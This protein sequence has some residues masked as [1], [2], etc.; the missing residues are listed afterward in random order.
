MRKI[1]VTLNIIALVVFFLLAPKLL[2]EREASAANTQGSGA[3]FNGSATNGCIDHTTTT[4]IVSNDVI[5]A[6]PV[7]GL[8]VYIW[9]T[10]G[11]TLQP[12]YVDVK[13]NV[14]NMGGPLT[15]PA[16][17][18]SPVSYDRTVPHSRFLFTPASATG[19]LCGDAFAGRL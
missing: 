2:T 10:V 13:G 5:P 12:V 17:E 16:N 18:L 19:N 1:L 15:I 9:S 8:D 7:R 4:Q 11:G 6:S 14:R 3:I